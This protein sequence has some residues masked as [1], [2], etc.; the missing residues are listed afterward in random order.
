VEERT[1][2]MDRRSILAVMAAPVAVV[3]VL[4]VPSPAAAEELRDEARAL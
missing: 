3:P 2:E 1:M 4:V